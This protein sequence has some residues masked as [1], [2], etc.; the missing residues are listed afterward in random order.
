MM[1]GVSTS[2]SADPEV[3]GE[4]GHEVR[5]GECVSSIAE[6][7][8]HFWQTL[9]DAPENRALREAR[10]DPNVLLPGDRVFVP[11]L[12]E[13]THACATGQVHRF[14]RRCVP[15][16]VRIRFTGEDGPRAQVGY[17]FDEGSGG[18][19]GVT[20]ADGFLE[21]WVSTKTRV[22]T[23]VFDDD[24]KEVRLHVGDL[25]PCNTPR[26]AAARL[27]SLGLASPGGSLS[28]ALEYFQVAH[29]LELTG[30]LDDGTI[31]ALTAAF[32]R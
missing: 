31:A 8:G 1:S 23:V 5:R 20:D 14:K 26:G 11:P 25:D 28:A 29:G 9:W 19:R 3:V 7:H 4:E 18:R 21:E 12:R 10:E 16:K 24:G 17:T 6:R 30:R 27:V 22:A 13:A 32:G 15:E 2:P